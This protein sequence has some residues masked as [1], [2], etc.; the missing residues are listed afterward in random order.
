M[1][2]AF[3]VLEYE[4]IPKGNLNAQVEKPMSRKGLWLK[5]KEDHNQLPKLNS[6][7]SQALSEL[8]Y[9]YYDYIHWPELG[10]TGMAFQ[11]YLKS[12]TQFFEDYFFSKIENL[13]PSL[14]SLPTVKSNFVINDL[15]ANLGIQLE[16]IKELGFETV[17]IKLGKNF[18]QELQII[19]K[20]NLTD[21]ELRLDFNSSQD[22]NTIKDSYPYLKKL[23]HIEY[24]EDPCAF[25][26]NN[27]QELGRLIPLAFDR[28]TSESTYNQSFAL[29]LRTVNHFII[30]PSRDL[31]PLNF[32]SLI[33]SSKKITLTNMMDSSLGAWKCYAY[34][35]LFIKLFPQLITT[36]GFYTHH[37]YKDPYAMEMLAFNG[38]S[39][40]AD[41]EKLEE[42]LKF[43]NK[44]NWKSL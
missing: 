14:N 5:R 44:K 31:N 39:W 34:H 27:W 38:A 26:Q 32:E 6:A 4:Q 7:L 9:N 3:Q 21:F 8:L 18:E 40:S 10:D 41:L 13:A 35:C 16:Q 15:N 43:L 33:K 19:L 17:K 23:P 24:C 29:A 37:L 36:P 25:E 12:E 1:P 11:K 2:S 20:H 30:K 22:F 28:P 42:F